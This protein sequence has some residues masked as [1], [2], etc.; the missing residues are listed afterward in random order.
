MLSTTLKF[1]IALITTCLPVLVFLI[2]YNQQTPIVR[3]SDQSAFIAF[4]DHITQRFYQDGLLNK[5]ITATNSNIHPNQDIHLTHPNISLLSPVQTIDWHIRANSAFMKKNQQ[6]VH[7]QDQVIISEKT[8]VF[9][10]DHLDI[11]LAQKT[12]DTNA[13]VSFSQENEH[14]TSSGMH[15]NLTTKEITLDANSS[16]S[17][18]LNNG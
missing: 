11:N 13:L 15:A 5:M 16:Y 12:A 4:S 2:L 1:K 14:G 9:S 10:T 7:L 8:R 17:I 18:N 3:P 6:T